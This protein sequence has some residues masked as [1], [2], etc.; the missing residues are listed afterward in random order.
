MSAYSDSVSEP[1]FSEPDSVSAKKN[2]ETEVEIG[3]SVRFRP[4]SSLSRRDEV[5]ENSAICFG[6]AAIS[7]GPACQAIYLFLPT[8]Y[9][10]TQSIKLLPNP[11]RVATFLGPSHYAHPIVVPCLPLSA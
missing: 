5:R 11:L 10:T 1:V 8:Y 4:F 7:V 2:I 6:L 3:F 9:P